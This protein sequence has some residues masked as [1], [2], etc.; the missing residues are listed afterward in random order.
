M[1]RTPRPVVNQAVVE[2]LTPQ[3]EEKELADG[4]QLT[5]PPP[6]PARPLP[7]PFRP[8]PPDWEQEERE[9]QAREREEEIDK[10]R[11]LL[12]EDRR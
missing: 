8:P 3:F 12:E 4:E 1:R 5:P 6:E 7:Q 11:A 2:M 9:R 10:A